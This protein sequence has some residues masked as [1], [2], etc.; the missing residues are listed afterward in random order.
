MAEILHRKG[1]KV[2]TVSAVKTVDVGVQKLLELRIGALVVTDRWGR[3]VGTLTERDIV[4]GLARYGIKI[5]SYNISEVMDQDVTTCR[6]DDRIDKV[7][8]LM[9]VHRVRYLP[10]MEGDRLI[11]IVSIGDLVKHRLE[12][13]EQE[14]NVL[15]DL[16]AMHG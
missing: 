4:R 16:R 8:Q 3:L 2:H 11:G 9:T 1:S 10:V 12:E 5:L 15:R 14:A 7:M 13:K 6:S